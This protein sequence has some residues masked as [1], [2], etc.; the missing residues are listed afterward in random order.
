MEAMMKGA[1][2]GLDYLLQVVGKEFVFTPE[3]YP[4]LSGADSPDTQRFALGHVQLHM[5]K[6][7]GTLAAELE[8]AEHGSG[9]NREVLEIIAA[10]SLINTLSLAKVL[11]LSPTI[12]VDRLKEVLAEANKKPDH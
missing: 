6:S 5:A 9:M 4:E 1:N 12:L 10:K 11:G 3:K 2:I 7:L 8:R